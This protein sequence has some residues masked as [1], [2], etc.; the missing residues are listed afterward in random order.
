MPAASPP[1]SRRLSWIEGSVLFFAVCAAFL[2]VNHQAYSNFFH[3]DT[4]DNMY[5]TSLVPLDSFRDGLLTWRYQ[6]SNF[7]PVGYYYFRVMR[8]VAGFN[9]P[10]WVAAVHLLHLATVG[11]LWL[12][13]R[14]MGARPAAA[15]A[16][17][18]FFAVH[19]AAFLC[20]WRPM[21]V[22]DVLCALFTLLCFY[23][24]M[25]GNLALSLVSFWLA[26]K[27]KEMAVAIPAILLAYEWLLGGRRW[28][29]VLPFAAISASLLAQVYLHNR[30]RDDDYT[31]RFTAEAL[32]TSATYYA[33]YIGQV[34][35]AGLA[36]LLLPLAVRDRRVVFGLWAALCLLAPML[37][38]PGRL[39]EAYLY[40]P[41]AGVGLAVT[42]VLENRPRW[43][44][45]AFAVL[46]LAGNVYLL[47][48][49]APYELMVA[50][51]NREYL[52]QVFDMARSHPYLR[53]VTFRNIPPDMAENGVAAI[54]RMALSNPKAKVVWA[55]SQE[56][57]A[58]V[59]LDDFA[60]TEWDHGLR[61]LLYVARKQGQQY[62]SFLKIGA[63]PPPWQLDRG[64]HAPYGE[65]VAWSSPESRATLRL[66]DSL[67]EF[68]VQV[69]AQREDLP[70]GGTLWIS[71]SIGGIGQPAKSV[72]VAGNRE[73]VWPIDAGM[74]KRLRANARDGKVGVELKFSPPFPLPLDKTLEAGAGVTAL[75]FR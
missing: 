53:A 30:T 57:P 66:P 16:G 6:P 5:W 14:R 8:R 61:K 15:A 10:A 3:D 26:Y 9:F 34:A 64:W 36:L 71:A 22:F 72:T 52:R 21:Y 60:A 24:Y 59:K 44:V 67:R 62:E 38:L 23:T 12:I 41:L 46:W 2:L 68:C 1:A 51:H 37:L 28:L 18:L 17:V 47:K 73:A 50:G 39:S 42:F 65:G 32:W 58:T 69:S 56:A 27:S 29:R 54:F 4:L 45:A 11:L 19:M 74:L 49:K 55:Q 20:Y 31:L 35:Y 33:R 7:R 25:R 43:A 70:P 75:G 63:M 13:V 48:R 40:L